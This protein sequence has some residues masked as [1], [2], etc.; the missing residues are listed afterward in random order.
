MKKALS[1]FW[2]GF[3]KIWIYMEPYDTMVL[4]LGW[5]MEMLGSE[6]ADCSCD[7]N[8]SLT[9]L[10]RRCCYYRPNMMVFYP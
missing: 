2:C 7:N 4:L 9:L 1:F 8:E 5:M 10:V 3:L 6:G